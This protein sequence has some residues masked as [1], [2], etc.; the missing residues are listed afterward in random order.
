MDLDRGLLDVAVH[1]LFELSVLRLELD[2][3]TKIL[4]HF[5][6][7]E[8]YEARVELEAQVRLKGDVDLLLR[9]GINHTFMVIELEA[10][11]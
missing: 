7:G 4:C 11:V 9:F 10:A 1:R 3:G 6:G 5:V 2:R 8:A